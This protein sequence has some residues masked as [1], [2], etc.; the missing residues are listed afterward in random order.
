MV[1]DLDAVGWLAA[2][3]LAIALL[4]Q[5]CWRVSAEGQIRRIAATLR[6]STEGASGAY[7]RYLSVWLDEITGDDGL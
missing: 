4:Y 6:G 2:L 7:C 3:V 5:T 1:S